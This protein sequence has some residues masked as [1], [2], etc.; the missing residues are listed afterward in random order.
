[1]VI[2]LII[3]ICG[4]APSFATQN[5]TYVRDKII[6]YTCEFQS[7]SY[8]EENEE[9]TI[10]GKHINSMMFDYDVVQIRSNLSNISYIPHEIFVKFENLLV[11]Q[12]ND[13]SLKSLEGAFERCGIITTMSFVHNDLTRLPPRNFEN[14]SSLLSLDVTDNQIDFLEL[15]AFDGI[16]KLVN[17]TFIRNPIKA[18]EPGVF[19]KLPNLQRLFMLR[20][21]MTELHPELLLNLK[22]LKKFEYGSEIP[23]EAITIKTRTFKSLPAL[24]FMTIKFSGVKRMDFEPAAFDDLPSLDGIDLFENSIRRLCANSFV[25][26]PNM[27]FL[28]IGE[29]HIM[30]IERTFFSSFPRLISVYA[31]NNGCVNKTFHGLDEAFYQSMENCFA[32][33]ENPVQ[34][35]TSTTTTTTEATTGSTE[36][37]TTAETTSTEINEKASDTTLGSSSII[38]NFMNVLGAF[39]VFLM[40]HRGVLA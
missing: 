12:V 3:A 10:I 5:C 36:M 24:D 16:E 4:I 27:T 18:I 1:M 17:L 19:D 6:G 23:F 20:N 37:R 40:V 32:N 28:A 22:S 11:L 9:F 39:A 31:V 29:N 38:P 21:E 26:V 25:N 34:E 14:C 15:G 2:S 35:T 8:L 7:I 33:F 13:S 30:E